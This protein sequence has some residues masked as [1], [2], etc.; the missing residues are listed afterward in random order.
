[1]LLGKVSDNNI[2]TV[3]LLAD[4]VLYTYTVLH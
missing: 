3:Y 1:M 2:I 4:A